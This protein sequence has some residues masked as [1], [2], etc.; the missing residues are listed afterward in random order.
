MLKIS[1]RRFHHKAGCL[2]CLRKCLIFRHCEVFAECTTPDLSPTRSFDGKAI[3]GFHHVEGLKT[4]GYA[5][6]Y[7]SRSSAQTC[8]F[9]AEYSWSR[10]ADSSPVTALLFCISIHWWWRCCLSRLLWTKLPKLTVELWS[11]LCRHQTLFFLISSCCC[12]C[13]MDSR[14]PCCSTF[15][16]SLASR[17]VVA[18][19][20]AC[21]EG[22]LLRQLAVVALLPFIPLSAAEGSV[23]SRSFM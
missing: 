6:D 1:A 19:K 18:A 16:C 10:C 3:N 11:R 15:L 12:C 17:W 21:I 8:K 20:H 13:V 2:R 14:V 4:T 23:L 22:Y 5:A 9:F 7:P